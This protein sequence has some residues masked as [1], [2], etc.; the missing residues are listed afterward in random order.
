MAPDGAGHVCGS[1]M[2]ETGSEERFP[3]CDGWEPVVE[4]SI[5]AQGQCAAR[6]ALGSGRKRLTC[7]VHTSPLGPLQGQQQGWGG[8]TDW[9]QVIADGGGHFW[10]QHPPCSCSHRC[11]PGTALA[12]LGHASVLMLQMCLCLSGT[13]SM[14]CFPTPLCPFPGHPPLK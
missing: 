7:R 1:W 6:P 11:C 14:P 2:V 9:P 4:L 3:W 13:S 10:H 5:P 12:L 8:G